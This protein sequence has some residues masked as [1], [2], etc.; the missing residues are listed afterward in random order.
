MAVTQQIAELVL[1]AK[2]EALDAVG[3]HQAAT[4][5]AGRLVET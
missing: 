5:L 1:T 2:A 4:K 3:E